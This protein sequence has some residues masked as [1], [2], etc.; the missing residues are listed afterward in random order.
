MKVEIYWAQNPMLDIE[1]KYDN[2]TDIENM[3]SLKSSVVV[4]LFFSLVTEL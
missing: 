2:S 4:I 1:F 3:H